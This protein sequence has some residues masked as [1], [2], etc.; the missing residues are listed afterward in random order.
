MIAGVGGEQVAARCWTG[1][2]QL[3]SGKDVWLSANCEH[4][5][6]TARRRLTSRNRRSLWIESSAERSGDQQ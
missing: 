3:L 4:P 1:E 2:E 6:K 5:A